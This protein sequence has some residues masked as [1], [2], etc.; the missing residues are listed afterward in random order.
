MSDGNEKYP[1]YYYL[2]HLIAIGVLR[3]DELGG[4]GIGDASA[5]PP[6]DSIGVAAADSGGDTTGSNAG[7]PPGT[8]IVDATANDDSGDDDDSD[9]DDSDDDSPNYCPVIQDE[10]ST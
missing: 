1:R 9:D 5:D 8:A 10:T 6:S 4:I 7:D 3:V 2:W